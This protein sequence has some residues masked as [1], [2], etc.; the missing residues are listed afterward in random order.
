MPCLNFYCLNSFD[1]SKI[2]ITING[3]TTIADEN[4]VIPVHPSMKYFHNSNLTTIIDNL[5]AWFTEFV[6]TNVSIEHT[7]LTKRLWV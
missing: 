5:T 1:R 4:T 3:T 7:N 6:I 2:M